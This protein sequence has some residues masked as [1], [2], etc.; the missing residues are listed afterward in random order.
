MGKIVL[1]NEGDGV[2]LETLKISYDYPEYILYRGRLFVRCNVQNLNGLPA[3][4]ERSYLEV[5]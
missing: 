4:C 5:D 3:Y 2:V 1:V